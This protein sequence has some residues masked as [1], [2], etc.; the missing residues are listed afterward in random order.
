[1]LVVPQ[2]KLE[3]FERPRTN[4]MAL[5]FTERIRIRDTVRRGLSLSSKPRGK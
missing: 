5:G 3:L 2:M 1:M 4:S